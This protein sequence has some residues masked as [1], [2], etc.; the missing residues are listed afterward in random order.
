MNRKIIIIFPIVALIAALI[1]LY[2]ALTN[3]LLGQAGIR[4]L[5]YCEHSRD[6]IVKQ[7]ANT[8]SNIGF[9]FAGLLIAWQ[10]LKEKYNHNIEQANHNAFLSYIF[11]HPMCT[12]GS[13]LD[14]YA[15]IYYVSW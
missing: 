4:G 5:D 10:M 1:L 9:I 7:P 3:G 12:D 15:R 8:Y 11:R 2:I 13:G 14:G 6:A